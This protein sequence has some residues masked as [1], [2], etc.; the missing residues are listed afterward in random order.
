MRATI[1]KIERVLEFPSY[2]IV[3]HTAPIQAGP[4][5]HYHWHMEIIP[6]VTR[7]AGF[8]WGAGFYIN[9]TP[10]EES[11]QFLRDAGL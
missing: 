7:V 3:L 2:N 4:L 1:R 6:R 8:E 11:A 5:S 9:P 10:P